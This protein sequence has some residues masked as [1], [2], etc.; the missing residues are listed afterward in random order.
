MAR[1]YTEEGRMQLTFDPTSRITQLVEHY[2][3]QVEDAY[4]QLATDEEFGSICLSFMEELDPENAADTNYCPNPKILTSLVR[5]T[6]NKFYPQFADD[7][8]VQDLSAAVANRL[9][10]RREDFTSLD[11][12]KLFMGFA[13]SCYLYKRLEQSSE[14]LEDAARGLSVGYPKI[15]KIHNAQQELEAITDGLE[16]AILV[17]KLTNGAVYTHD[18]QKEPVY[19]L[20]H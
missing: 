18:R 15:S 1:K 7:E 16:S 20:L 14:A 12:A 11:E 19:G 10:Y 17:F 4:Y 13:I 6:I 3:K 9:A 8:E 5:S 2:F